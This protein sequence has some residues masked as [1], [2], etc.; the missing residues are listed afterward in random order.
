M[1]CI[2]HNTAINICEDGQIRL[3]GGDI[4][5]EG[6]VELCYKGTWTTICSRNFLNENNKLYKLYVI[7]AQLGY[8]NIINRGMC[9]NMGSR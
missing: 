1:L 5:Q 4:V 6:L 8:S 9:Y 7:C 3:T 2:N